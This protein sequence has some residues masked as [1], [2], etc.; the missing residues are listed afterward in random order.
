MGRDILRYGTT[1]SDDRWRMT[2]A[3]PLDNASH[4]YAL[5][6]THAPP[7]PTPPHPTPRTYPSKETYETVFLEIDTTR[8]QASVLKRRFRGALNTTTHLT[9]RRLPRSGNASGRR[10]SP[11]GGSCAS[12]G[13]EP[14]REAESPGILRRTSE[15]AC[16]IAAI[17]LQ[18]PCH[19][20]S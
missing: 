1:E 19:S 4:G 5:P 10:N 9:D 7:D 3:I 17:E 15:R 16:E 14:R 6:P 8:T 2:R 13:S 12:T 20:R 18:E 11:P